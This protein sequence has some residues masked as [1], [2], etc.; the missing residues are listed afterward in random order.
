VS[1]RRSRAPIWTQPAPGTRRP[2]FTRERIAEVALAIA[3]REGFEALSMR[4]LADELGAGTMTVYHY[5]RTKDDLIALLDDAIMA[6]VVV[7]AGELPVHWRPAL[8]AIARRS[9]AAF[10]R[11]PWALQALQSARFGPNGLHHFEQSLAAVAATGLPLAERMTILN[12][13]DDFVFGHTFRSNDD[14]T[15]GGRNANELAWI[16]EVTAAHVATGH[17]PHIAEVLGGRNS[18]AAWR[19]VAELL[20]DDG[21]FERGL[22]AILDG[23]ALRWQLPAEE[24]SEATQAV[25]P[26]RSRTP[27]AGGPRGEPTTRTR[28]PRPA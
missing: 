18:A 14:R 11:H 22:A 13:V 3:D 23:I 19:R 8:T 20:D 28:K 9:H 25:R 12:I 24:A 6:E 1:T 27:V 21:R 10:H 16:V 17:Y 7:P 26:A 5:V 2:R 15:R 4:R